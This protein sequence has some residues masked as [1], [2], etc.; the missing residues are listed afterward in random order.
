MTVL[1]SII[2]TSYGLALLMIFH[3]PKTQHKF[4]LISKFHS[5][6]A[7][8]KLRHDLYQSAQSS[9][10][11]LRPYSG[12]SV[13]NKLHLKRF[14]SVFCN[15]RGADRFFSIPHLNKSAVFTFY[16]FWVKGPLSQYKPALLCSKIARQISH[17]NE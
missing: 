11:C 1:V 14:M 15:R 12:K 13:K 4:Y 2:T 5:Q 8:S 10:C 9:K 16:L 7:H 3:G 17:E 6:S